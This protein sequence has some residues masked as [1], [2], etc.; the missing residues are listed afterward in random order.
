MLAV[1]DWIESTRPPVRMLMQVHDELVFEVDALAVTSATA[2]IK[3]L[4]EG[5]ADL[6]VPLV[7]DVGVGDNWEEAH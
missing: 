6:Q 5:A 1:D 2:E 7:V 4:M 3:R